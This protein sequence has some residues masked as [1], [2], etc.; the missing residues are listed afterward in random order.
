MNSAVIGEKL[1]DKYIFIFCVA[2]M[3]L[4]RLSFC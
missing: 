4:I 3:E 1:T 2:S